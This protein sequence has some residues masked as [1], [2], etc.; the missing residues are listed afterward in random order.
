MVS[1][2]V[3]NKLLEV[4][5]LVASEHDKWLRLWRGYQTFYQV[6][7]SDE[8]SAETWRR[9]HDP[10]EPI[11]ALGGFIDSALYG[12]TH[13][14]FHRSCWAIENYCY[15]QDLYTA[16][17]KRGNGLGTALIQAVYNRARN[18]GANRVHWLTTGS[19]KTACTIY[20]RLAEKSG[21]IQ[22]RIILPD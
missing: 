5:P 6:S 19:N 8:V 21:F 20:D 7:I 2:G 16:P 1:I 11:F 4:R 9:F 12:F 15:L 14:I 13:Y 17:E 22:Y 10:R 3:N 18:A